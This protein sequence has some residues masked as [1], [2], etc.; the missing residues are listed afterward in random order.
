ME[1]GDPS[2]NC[3]IWACPL[4][5]LLSWKNHSLLWSCH[6]S[7][8]GI[9]F[10]LSLFSWPAESDHWECYRFLESTTI[11]YLNACWNAQKMNMG[12]VKNCQFWCCFS[13]SFIESRGRREEWHWKALDEK[14][15]PMG[16]AILSMPK[17]GPHPVW[18]LNWPWFLGNY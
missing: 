11:N 10:F 7:S 1:S 8:V 17:V 6:E 15:N 9:S 12:P 5:R 14:L 3:P 13:Y 18:R 16:L 2:I 4:L